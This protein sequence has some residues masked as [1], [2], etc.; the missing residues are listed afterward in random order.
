I[1]DERLEARPVTT[2]CISCKKEQEDM[3][4]AGGL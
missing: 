2:Y 1:G 3:E 4:K